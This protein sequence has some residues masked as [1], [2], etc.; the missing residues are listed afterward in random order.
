MMATLLDALS[1]VPVL[2]WSA[3]LL[4]FFHMRKQEAIVLRVLHQVER[5]EERVQALERR[6]LTELQ[7][8]RKLYQSM[9]L[10]FLGRSAQRSKSTCSP[11]DPYRGHCEA[12][13]PDSV[14]PPNPQPAPFRIWALVEGEWRELQVSGPFPSKVFQPDMRDGIQ[15][16]AEGNSD[17]PFVAWKWE[18]GQGKRPEKSFQEALQQVDGALDKIRRERLPERRVVREGNR[19]YVEWI[20]PS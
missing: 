13:E 16:L 10:D 18:T 14:C 19:S 15:L 4:F 8:L 17:T 3:V 5:T 6:L 7:E 11:Q 1:R 2:W 9:R 20:Y 12:G